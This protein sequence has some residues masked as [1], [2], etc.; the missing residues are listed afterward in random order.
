MQ[1]VYKSSHK[2]KIRWLSQLEDEKTE[3]GSVYSPDFYDATG[4]E[5]TFFYS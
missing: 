4:T 2:I 5:P 1:N 3:D